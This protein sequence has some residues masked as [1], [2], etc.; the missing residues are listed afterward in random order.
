MV[1]LVYCLFLAYAVAEDG[2]G[3]LPPVTRGETGAV[4]AIRKALAAGDT[5]AAFE[6]ARGLAVRQP[7]SFD[8]HLWGGYF[9][10]RQGRF[11][12]AVRELRR[13][14]AVDARATVLVLVAVAYH[15][16]HQD[17]LFV[18]K[19]R[20]AIAKDAS[21]FA[22]RYYLGRYYDSDAAQFSLA[23]EHFRKAIERNPRHVRSH[24]YLGHSYEMEQMAGEAEV[25]YRR[26]LA[27]DGEASLPNQGL[28][29]LRLAAGKPGEALPFARAAARS[30]ESDAAARKLLAQVY[31]ELGR[32]AEAM[33]EWKAAAALDPA[34]AAPLYRLYRYYLSNGQAAEARAALDKYRQVAAR[35]GGN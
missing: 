30:G 17:K 10:V 33:A 31:S 1:G 23:A 24:Y 32:Q 22:P 7:G 20:D 25:C 8:A 3:L 26:A 12:D 18:Q 34:D 2:D 9:A 5:K 29:R 16:A 15:G 19:M 21:L 11:L 4:T 35:Y 13:A 27:L 14:E 6:A 28:A